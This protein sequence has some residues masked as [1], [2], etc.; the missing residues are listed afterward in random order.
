MRLNVRGEPRKVEKASSACDLQAAVNV[1][2][3]SAEVN[4]QLQDETA[5]ARHAERE[6]F[7]CCPLTC[8][9][10]FFLVWSDLSPKLPLPR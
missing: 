9:V 8:G 7:L 10:T 2:V 1:L 3:Q 5:E 4:R 6:Q